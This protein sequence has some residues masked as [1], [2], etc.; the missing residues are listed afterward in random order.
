MG[1]FMVAGFLQIETIVDV[2]ELPLPYKEF[3]SIPDI[4]N[5]QAGRDADSG[6][7]LC[8]GQKA[9]F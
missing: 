9:D 3:E 5:T 1:K 6:R 2:D 4:I 7:S 8:Q